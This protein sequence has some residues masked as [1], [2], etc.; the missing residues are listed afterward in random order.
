M[1]LLL[2]YAFI[3][4]FF[5]FLC[6]ILEA[7]LLSVTHTFVSVGKSEG[8]AYITELEALKKDVDKPLISILT[9]N[10]IAHTVGAI[11]VGV[12][13]KV[14]YL[15]L[16]GDDGFKVFGFELSEGMMVGAVSSVMTV[17]ILVA[18]EIIP[19]T[20]GA[21]YWK[22]LAKFSTKTLVLMV[23]ALKYTGLLWLLQLFT[24]LVGSKDPHATKLTREDFTAMASIAHQEGAVEE[25]ESKVVRNVLRLSEMTAKDVM[26]PRSVMFMV[27]ES[28]NL[29]EFIEEVKDKP[30][31]RIPVFGENRDDITGVVIRSQAFLAGLQDREGWSLSKVR[32]DVHRVEST[33]PLDK[34]MKNFLDQSHHFSL[35][36]DQFGTVTGLLTLEDILET[37]VGVEILDETDQVADLQALARQLWRERAS[38]VGLDTEALEEPEQAATPQEGSEKN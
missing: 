26:T 14:A 1:G 2:F 30:F 19:K 13:A 17:L 22:Q 27:K 33:E 20:I 34:L 15:Q 10:T 12:Q 35:V 32:R 3:S 9:L 21:T 29:D 7:V 18:S 8:K 6:S 37:V 31:S 11:L 36:T 16:K 25:S 38:K 28:A 4:I 24:R 5:S 23:F